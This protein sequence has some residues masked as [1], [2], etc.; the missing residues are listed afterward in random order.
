MKKVI[1][2]IIAFVL[3]LFLVSLIIYGISIIPL[4]NPN[5][6]KMNEIYENTNQVAKEYYDIK[7]NIASIVEDSRI[8]EEEYQNI[9]SLYHHFLPLFDEITVG[10]DLTNTF[11]DS[12][13]EK[14]DKQ[15]A[16][17]LTSYNYQIQKYSLYENGIAIIIYILYFG[18]FAYFTKGQTL[19]KKVFHLRTV[20]SLDEK[21]SI[22]LWKYI[23]RA[24][25]ICEV[26]LVVTDMIFVVTMKESIYT[27]ANYWLTQAKYIYEVAFLIVLIIRDDQRSIHDLLLNTRVLRYDKEGHEIEE[28]IFVSGEEKESENKK[29][30]KNTN[31]NN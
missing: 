17:Y 5:I 31:K 15:Y 29:D 26:I 21:A 19:F 1:S 6:K 3:D 28:Q 4:F 10:E 2:R 30:E 8:T 16:S 22:P 12:I 14:I 18:V 11:I 25:L 20:D 9:T 23:V 7:E 13:E 27:T 24:I